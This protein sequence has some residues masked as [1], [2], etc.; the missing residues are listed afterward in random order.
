MYKAFLIFTL[1][2]VAGAVIFSC[3]ESYGA[4]KYVISRE[5]L[6]NFSDESLPVLNKMLRDM[7][8][9]IDDIDAR[10]VAGGH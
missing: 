9:C 3:G 2:L 7:W 4:K 10:L 8:W 1:G 6:S 5:T